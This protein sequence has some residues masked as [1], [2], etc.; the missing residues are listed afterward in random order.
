MKKFFTKH[1]S[2]AFAF[3]A[4]LTVSVVTPA[5]AQNIEESQIGNVRFGFNVAGYRS[6][7]ASILKS[8]A[9]S[10]NGGAKTYYEFA[11]GGIP[12]SYKS[13]DNIVT[14]GWYL[15]KDGNIVI[16]VPSQEYANVSSYALTSNVYDNNEDANLALHYTR[17]Y[18]LG[19][20][21]NLK[22]ITNLNLRNRFP[23]EG[24]LNAIYGGDPLD[25]YGSPNSSL[26]ASY[27]GA[28]PGLDVILEV[29]EYSDGNLSEPSSENVMYRFGDLISYTSDGYV[30]G[31]YGANELVGRPQD[32][33]A[34]KKVWDKIFSHYRITTSG[35]ENSVASFL[36]M[37]GSY[38]SFGKERIDVV[39]NNFSITD[40][41]YKNSMKDEEN[42]VYTNNNEAQN[43][44][45]EVK[46]NIHFEPGSTLTLGG[47]SFTLTNSL[48]VSI[49]LSYNQTA[50]NF[51]NSDDGSK[52]LK[53]TIYDDMMNG[54]SFQFSLPAL[55]KGINELIGLSRDSEALPITFNFSNNKTAEMP[56]YFAFGGNANES[57]NENNAENIQNHNEKISVVGFNRT[58][59]YQA[60]GWYTLCLPFNI[61]SDQLK[62]AFGDNVN[63]R[64]YNETVDNGDGTMTFKF[65]RATEVEA[66]HPYLIRPSKD[67]SKY[68]FKNVTVS[69]TLADGLMQA[70][71]S[72]ETYAFKG[73]FTNRTL[74]EFGDRARF[75]GGSK[76]TQMFKATTGSTLPATRCYFL[77]PETTTSAAKK[78]VFDLGDGTTT[79]IDHIINS[80]DNASANAPVYNVRGQHVGNNLY[81]LPKGVYIQNGKK[82]IK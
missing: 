27:K 79:G 18:A 34:A 55:F 60:D 1:V 10:Y 35:N 82:V 16:T 65:Q 59:A 64:K 24:W 66:G 57:I 19:E 74:D 31:Y 29:N 58:M 40:D 45:E 26:N 77:Y 75:F 30:N 22:E 2:M 36:L 69:N 63:L 4:A 53:Q 7:D 76:G 50:L 9:T 48:T 51:I 37:P 52:F 43:E 23:L 71:G 47:T 5:N 11:N 33:E 68:Y 8:E 14:V 62:A 61:P 56:Y 12:E 80:N 20:Y 38:I 39:G 3:A 17:D 54:T 42:V 41:F 70:A 13:A 78:L 46:F 73:T 21:T 15:Q 67:F 25:Q 6:L 72:S 32:A 49:D 81:G 44:N 28:F